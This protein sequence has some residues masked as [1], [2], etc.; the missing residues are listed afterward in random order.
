MRCSGSCTPPY[1]PHY[2]SKDLQ[3][4][5][6]KRHKPYCKPGV[7]MPVPIEDAQ[8]SGLPSGGVEEGPSSG[9]SAEGD[10]IDEPLP[11]D[12]SREYMFR[13]SVPQ[14]PGGSV[15]IMSST[16]SPALMREVRGH[17]ERL[18]MEDMMAR[19]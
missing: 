6:W 12:P 19:Q 11:A 15:Q 10:I 16:M 2:C 7:A 14:V 4:Q 18:A 17:I 9:P 1:K 3:T 8:A 13:A 5:D